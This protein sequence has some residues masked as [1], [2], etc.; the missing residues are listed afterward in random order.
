MQRVNRVRP[1]IY[2]GYEASWLTG[3]LARLAGWRGWLAGWR[4]WLAGIRYCS[5]AAEPNNYFS[6]RAKYAPKC[7]G[8]PAIVDHTSMYVASCVDL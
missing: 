2:P 4:G 5:A 7:R 1:E 6:A 8:R 3:W